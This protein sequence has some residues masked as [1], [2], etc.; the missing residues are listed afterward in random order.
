MVQPNKSKST[1]EYFWS[2][3]EPHREPFRVAVRRQRGAL[4]SDGDPMRGLRRHDQEPGLDEERR[5]LIH[6]YMDDLDE[7][8]AVV[9]EEAPAP[10]PPAAVEWARAAI[11]TPVARPTVEVPHT[12]V[13]VARTVAPILRLPPPAPPPR[14]DAVDVSRRRLQ[15]VARLCEHVHWARVEGERRRAQLAASV[16]RWRT[17]PPGSLPAE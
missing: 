1:G 10:D 2:T 13:G 9:Q 3:L 15:Q 4:E 17:S 8:A 7:P 11:P 5:R 6:S 12:E 16:A 14:R